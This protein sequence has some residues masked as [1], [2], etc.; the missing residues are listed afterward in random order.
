[1]NGAARASALW[2]E[3][4]PSELVGCIGGGRDRDG[5]PRSCF[6]GGRRYTCSGC[7]R[8]VPECFG[9]ADAHPELCDDC[10]AR[11]AELE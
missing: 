3:G 2:P 1:M 10:A 11:R 5:I 6:C 4:A 7:R 9:A 8:F